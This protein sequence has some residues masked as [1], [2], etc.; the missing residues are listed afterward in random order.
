MQVFIY[1][2]CE[3]DTGE[4]RYVGSSLNPKARLTSHLS[5]EASVAVA[6]WC[7]KLGANGA[8]PMLA[9][10]GEEPDDIRAAALEAKFIAQLSRPRLL[11]VRR[12]QPLL[13]LRRARFKPVRLRE[14]SQGAAL[15]R[16]AIFER[17]WTI[18][19]AQRRLGVGEGTVSRLVNG[20]RRPGRDLAEHIRQL[21]G[22][23][24]AAWG[25]STES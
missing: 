19:E 7:A 10:L 24:P 15:L 4:I 20:R 9:I 21:F 5:C 12:G 13:P 2:L 18:N 14:L 23:E 16:L 11:N 6:K 17:D 25:R 1:A 22:V 3:P 8:S